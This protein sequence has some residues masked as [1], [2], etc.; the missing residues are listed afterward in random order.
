MLSVFYRN[1]LTWWRPRNFWI[2]KFKPT[3]QDLVGGRSCSDPLAFIVLA[4]DDCD[5]PAE[6]GENT[7]N[8]NRVVRSGTSKR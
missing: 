1:A 4:M 6:F 5:R 7:T 2:R 8:P 3:L